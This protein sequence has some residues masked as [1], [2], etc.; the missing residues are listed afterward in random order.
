MVDTSDSRAVLERL[1]KERREDYAGLSRLI[2]RNPAYIQQFI[3]RGTPKKLDEEDRR[4]LARYFG[5]DESWLGGAA[6]STQSTDDLVEVPVLDVRASAGP[7]ALAELEAPRGRFAFDQRWLRRLTGSKPDALSIITVVGDSMFPTLAD[8][9]EV[10]VDRN[11]SVSRLRDGIYVLR[12]DDT[13]MIKRLAMG[14]TGRRISVRSD[15]EAYPSWEDYDLRRLEIVG[16]VL[17]Y[18]RKLY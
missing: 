15:N 18:G 12:V 16:R 10:I 3:K 4:T 17:W 11:D 7:G 13:L 8:G 2:G 1:I 5:V 14:P 6:S 9:D